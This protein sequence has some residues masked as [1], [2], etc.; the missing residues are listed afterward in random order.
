MVRGDVACPHV[1][2][3]VLTNSPETTD[4][5]V[6][7]LVGRYALKAF[8]DHA[9]QGRRAD[10][11]ARFVYYEYLKEPG[12]GPGRSLHSKVMV[13]GPDL[14]IGSANAD[15][16]SYVLDSNNGLYIRGA[17]R[18]PADYLQ[19]VDRILADPRESEDRTR[20]FLE[21]PRGRLL[22]EDRA[23]IGDV[24]RRLA[25]RADPDAVLPVEHVALRLSAI[26]EKAYRLSADI[27]RGGREAADAERLFDALF[28]VL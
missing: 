27:V 12:G 26:L 22:D 5:S 11:G 8:A 1:D 6:I 19:A 14:F 4:L 7:N 15:V 24:I 13:L 21:T 2:V 25:G 20:Y 16:R 10:R 9:L 23:R 17:P 3:V 28:K 18:L